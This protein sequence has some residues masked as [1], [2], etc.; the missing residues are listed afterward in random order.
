MS[1][2]HTGLVVESGPYHSLGAGDRL[3]LF[4]DSKAPQR[5]VVVEVRRWNTLAQ[6]IDDGRPGPDERY[7]WRH[8]WI[9]RRLAAGEAV[10][11]RDG[12]SA[13]LSVFDGS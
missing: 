8:E 13:D 9:A 10:R 4:P 6:R 7:V 5:W 12:R 1:A 11:E 3:R 2:D